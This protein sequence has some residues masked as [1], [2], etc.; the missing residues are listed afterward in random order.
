MKP[1]TN[2]AL[3]QIK[4]IV[5]EVEKNIPPR[6]ANFSDIRLTG[7][8]TPKEIIKSGWTNPFNCLEK[9]AVIG[10]KIMELGYATK[11]IGVKVNDAKGKPAIMHFYLFIN[12]PGGRIYV[13]PFTTKSFISEK[14]YMGLDGR[15]ELHLDPKRW[16]IPKNAMDTPTF[17]LIGVKGISGF[18][19]L[20]G[21]SRSRITWEFVKRS[22]LATKI[23][24]TARKV[25]KKVVK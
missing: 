3:S 2:P 15:R 10:A 18:C 8:R 21:I 4:D 6:R 11:I 23:K 19:K 13:N 12:T 5:F 22:N 20:A 24:R 17:K 9:T 7:K 14:F 1:E 16:D 25:R